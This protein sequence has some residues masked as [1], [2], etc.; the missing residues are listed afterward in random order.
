ML[1]A[2]NQRHPGDHE[3]AIVALEDLMDMAALL[4][5]YGPPSALEVSGKPWDFNRVYAGVHAVS[6]SV[7][8][9]TPLSL[10][11][12]IV[13]R[14]VA[15]CG[16]E[17]CWDCSAAPLQAATSREL[18]AQAFRQAYSLDFPAAYASLDEAARLDPADPAAARA[19]AAIT[20]IELL[21]VQGAATF[22]AFTG[23]ASKEDVSRPVPTPSL[24]LRFK[25]QIERAKRLADARLKA[26]PDADAHYQIRRHICPRRHLRGDGGRPYKRG[27]PRRASRGT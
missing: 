3:C 4:R 18:T 13:V 8:R 10:T 22:E 5:R 23:Q 12:C 16:S 20:W 9:S 14:N 11:R 17:S 26:S 6:R 19:T 2:R 25:T 27:V 7:L 15:R 24:A 21:L 1:V